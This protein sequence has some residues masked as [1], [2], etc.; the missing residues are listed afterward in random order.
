MNK[1]QRTVLLIG[2]IVLAI[3]VLFL[4]P[5]G[6]EYDRTGL[7]FGPGPRPV[8]RHSFTVERASIFDP[9]YGRSVQLGQAALEAGVIAVLTGAITL[10]V[11]D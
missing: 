7:V 8:E 9:P 5:W 3:Y 10:F 1:K 4:L 6:G 11:K 2:A